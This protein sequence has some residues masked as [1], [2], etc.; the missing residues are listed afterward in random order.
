[1]RRK[2]INSLPQLID[3][4]NEAANV[5]A[6]ERPDDAA[7]LKLVAAGL[8][9]FDG[10]AFLWYASEGRWPFG[11][12]GASTL[13]DA[14]GRAHYRFVGVH[15]RADAYDLVLDAPDEESLAPVVSFVVA[16]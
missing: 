3:L 8:G 14:H 9:N 10:L 12:D 7:A 2:T 16:S 15:D 5:A 1:M 13:A 4:V 11:L 6:D